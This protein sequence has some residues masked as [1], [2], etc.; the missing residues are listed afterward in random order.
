MLGT[1]NQTHLASKVLGTDDLAWI[2]AIL[3]QVGLPR[4]QPKNPDG[5][6]TA[7]FVRRSGRVAHYVWSGKIDAPDLRAHHGPRCAC[8]ERWGT[9]ADLAHRD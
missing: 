4:S 8:E 1:V 6:P 2:H 3:T 9:S 7:E 5:T